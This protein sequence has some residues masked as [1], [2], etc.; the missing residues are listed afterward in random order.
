MTAM[1]NKGPHSL[2]CKQRKRHE[3]GMVGMWG[4]VY[5]LNPLY[6][7]FFNK[8]FSPKKKKKTAI[9]CI[10]NNSLRRN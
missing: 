4:G 6:E 7:N 3:V 9:F 2:F 1:K 10:L 5:N 8:K